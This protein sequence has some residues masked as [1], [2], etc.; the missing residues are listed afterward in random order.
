MSKTSVAVL[1]GGPSH[2]YEISLKTGGSVL[3]HLPEKYHPVD[4]FISK[5]GEWHRE[6]LV[7]KP[8]EA[9]RNVDV[10]FNALHGHY[11]ED[12][13]VQGLLDDIGVPYTGPDKI[14][15]ALSMHKE[16][17]KKIFQTQGIKVPEHRRVTPRDNMDVVTKEIFETMF[18]PLIVKP[19]AS[20]SSVGMT[21]VYNYKD[22]A[23]AIYHAFGHS[24][25]VLV[26][27]YI[28]GREAT[29]GVVE[30]FRGSRHYALMPVEIICPSTKQFFDYEAKY[31]G[32]TEERCPGNFSYEEKKLIEEATIKAHHA[33]GLR[34]YSRS[35]FILTPR[36]NLYILETNSLPGLTEA[37]L[38]PRSLEAVGSNLTEFVDHVITLSHTP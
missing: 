7:K 34:H 6:G 32:E 14:S 23:E 38:L 33:L 5:D 13:Q 22:L 4:I 12:G 35:D 31:S 21:L 11:G 25:V 19:V 30:G 9:L 18:L 37:S 2:E 28:K 29:C 1:R 27:Q 24:D 8:H 15:A 3:K 20:G 36:G 16:H 17:A 26:E 10:V